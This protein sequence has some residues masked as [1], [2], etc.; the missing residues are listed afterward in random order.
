MASIRAWLRN[1]RILIYGAGLHGGGITT[2]T[3]AHQ[4]GARVRVLD[5]IARRDHPH[6]NAQVDYRGRRA[7]PA[8]PWLR[9]AELVVCAPGLPAAVA[10]KLLRL[11]IRLTTAEA[12]FMRW[13]RGPR[14]GI[15]GT[16]GKSATAAFF[17]R[18]LGWPFIGNSFGH[19]LAVPK[20]VATAAGGA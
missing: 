18:M 17:A 12:L 5:R 19:M 10:T 7:A 8:I 6:G 20:I 1:R 15:T 2:A 14:I 13:H 9:W 3:I 11:G 4:C 16:K